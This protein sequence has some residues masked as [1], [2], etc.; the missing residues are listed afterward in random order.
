MPS[1]LNTS[2]LTRLRPQ[3]SSSS[4]GVPGVEFLMHDHGVFLPSHM[5]QHSRTMAFE[6]CGILSFVGGY[7]SL[8]QIGVVS[9]LV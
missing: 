6:R 1:T 8:V 5:T 3:G 9:P 7:P 2:P 4:R